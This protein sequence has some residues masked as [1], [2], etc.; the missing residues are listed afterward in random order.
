[1]NTSSQVATDLRSSNHRTQV[2]DLEKSDEIAG[3]PKKRVR[4]SRS[5]KIIE[6]LRRAIVE[7][8]FPR[9]TLAVVTEQGFPDDKLMDSYIIDAWQDSMDE[10]RENGVD[11]GGITQD[12]KK[13]EFDLVRPFNFCYARATSQA[14]CN[15]L[16][17]Y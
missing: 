2:A 8:A 16:T 9:I 6:K 11:L 14:F 3:L 10:L 4:K 17:I 15:L 12:I 5:I 13:E 7:G 1:M